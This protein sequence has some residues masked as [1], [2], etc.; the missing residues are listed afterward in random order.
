[1]NASVRPRDRVPFESR[2]AMG[3]EEAAGALGISRNLFNAMVDDG[4]MPPPRVVN[5][6]RLWDVGEVKAAFRA[7]PRDG[8][9]V[10]A[11]SNINP[12]DDV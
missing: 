3:R 1:M 2:I 8:E 4:R 5:G 12:W 6:R 7:I 9:A 10:S 11:H